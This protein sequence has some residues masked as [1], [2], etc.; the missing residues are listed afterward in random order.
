MILWDTEFV[1]SLVYNVLYV[2]PSCAICMV[3]F[4][5]LLK[6]LT[7]LDKLHPVVKRF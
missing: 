3:V 6:P 4:S 1:G 5:L 2:G 7:S